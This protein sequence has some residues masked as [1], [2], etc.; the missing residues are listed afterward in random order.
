MEDHNTKAYKFRLTFTAKSHMT[1]ITLAL[2]GQESEQTQEAIRVI[3][4]ILRQHS[5]MQYV[6]SNILQTLLILLKVSFLTF[7]FFLKGLPVGSSVI[8]P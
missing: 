2:R 5:S 6:L 3:N 1:A 8:L 4:V 7:P